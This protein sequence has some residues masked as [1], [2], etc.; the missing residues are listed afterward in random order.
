[1][2]RQ[3]AEPVRPPWR[4]RSLP[5]LFVRPW[6]LAGRTSDRTQHPAVLGG[7]VLAACLLGAAIT[8]VPP[9]LLVAGLGGSALI[10]I[11]AIRPPVAAYVLIG[12][13]PLIA[14]IDRGLVIPVLR[15][16]EALLVLVAGGLVA[17]GIVRPRSASLPRIR[18]DR[19]NIS[20]LILAFTASVLPLAWMLTRGQAITQ[21]DILYA[22]IPWKYYAVY[23]VTLTSIRTER[24]VRTCLWV[25]MI[26]GSIVAVIAILESLRLFGITGALA[27]YYKPYGNVQA[28][29]NSRGGSTLALPIA[30]ADL[31][32]FNLAVAIGLLIRGPKHRGALIALAAV[33]LAGTLAAGEFSGVIGLVLAIAVIAIVTRRVR[34][35]IGFAPA[36]LAA[37]YALRPVIE[38]RTRGFQSASG[39]PVSWAGRLANLRNYFWPVL[40]S[41]GNFI[42]GV[43]PAARVPTATMATGYIWIESGYTWLLWSGGIPFLLAFFYFVGANLRRCLSV[44]RSRDDAVGA[45]ALAAVVGLAIVT[46][47]ML[48]D[49]HLTYRGSADWL[50]ALLALASI[51]RGSDRAA[52]SASSTANA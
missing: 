18:M 20:I 3:L 16:N 38:E 19:T 31:M 35:V 9:S 17:R 26:A 44:T 24:Q 52:A 2:A 23:L 5:R 6:R 1:V 41:H 45:A 34:P 13:T 50:F 25:G 7:L 22:L 29:L 51:G 33:F 32:I 28:L 49:P 42:L 10:A 11:V 27:T 30:E 47:L 37:G 14:G 40:F 15:P 8:V 12:G 21:D 4:D 36:L 48:L 46:V 43:R 39:L